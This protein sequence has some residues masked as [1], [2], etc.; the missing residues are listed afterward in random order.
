MILLVLVVEWDPDELDQAFDIRV[1]LVRP[2]GED[3]AHQSLSLFRKPSGDYVA[4]APMYRHLVYQFPI[5]FWEVGRHSLRIML[6][7]EE[8]ALV[9]FGVRV[10]LPLPEG[11]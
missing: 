11:Y 7:A 5:K 1:L 10:L 6:R 8:L 3:H 9:H 2:S 4:G